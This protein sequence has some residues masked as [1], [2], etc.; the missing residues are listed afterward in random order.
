[1]KLH[2][3]V[4]PGI[5][6][7]NTSLVISFEPVVDLIFVHDISGARKDGKKLILGGR[8]THGSR[9]SLEQGFRF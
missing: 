9:M 5:V 7:T 3:R 8:W 1:M 2:T 4:V 6:T